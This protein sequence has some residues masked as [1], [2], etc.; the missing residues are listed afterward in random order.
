MRLL[1]MLFILHFI[2]TSM[3]AQVALQPINE[4]QSKVT[5]DISNMGFNTVEGSF[6]GMAG[7]IQFDENNLANALFDVCIDAATVNTDNEARDKH[8]RKEDFFDV[9]EYP[10]ICFASQEFI[11][12]ADGYIVKGNLSMHGVTN[13]IEIPFTFN[14]NTFSGNF[15]IQRLDYGVGGKGGF[16]VGKEVNVKISCVLE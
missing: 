5:F 15:T 9:E 8:L 11:K 13:I 14:D 12:T 16:M 2:S 7:T 10:A 4:Q 3:L 1:I 6:T